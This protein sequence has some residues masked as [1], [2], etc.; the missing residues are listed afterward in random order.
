M[1]TPLVDTLRR[2]L[3]APAPSGFET[4]AS[5]V[6]REIASDFASEVWTDASGN[7]YAA[8]GDGD[9]PT[10]MLAGHIDEIGLMVHYIDDDGYLFV[11]GVGGWDPQVLVGQRVDI[12]AR[13]GV[14]SGVIGRRAIHLVESDDRGKAVKLKDLWVDIGAADADEARQRVSI[15]DVGVIRSDTLQMG[16]TRVAA[17]SIDDRAGAAVALEAL[18]RIV[19]RGSAA[20]VV[21]VAT[22]QEEISFRSGGGARTSSFGL[23]PDAAIV[24]D[25]TH[26]TD[27]PHIDKK[28]HGDIRLG[29]GPVLNRGAVIHPLVLEGLRAAAAEADIEVQWQAA[30]SATG[31]DADSI[32]TSRAGIPTAVVSIPNRYMHSPN[33]LIDLG[34]LDAAA[35]LI[36]GYLVA[37]EED[38]TFAPA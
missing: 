9:G 28:E 6:W 18:R 14:V 3:D 10:V 13:D 30:P 22:A 16:E 7:A 20:R 12:L 4:A 38:A 19:E 2:L 21:A 24:I 23:D 32:F 15:G 26:A 35:E 11:R 27:H 8:A 17:R 29:S 37:L 5:R 36:A 25:V 1:S 31:T 33:Q 34:D